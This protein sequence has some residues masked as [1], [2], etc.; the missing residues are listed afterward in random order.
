MG[1]GTHICTLLFIRDRSIA[2]TFSRKF[3]T[4]D[5]SGAHTFIC[6]TILLGTEVCVICQCSYSNS[7]PCST[8][9]MVCWRL[10][11]RSSHT[12]CPIPP[13]SPCSV[14]FRDSPSVTNITIRHL[15][16]SSSSHDV[17]T[18]T[19]ARWHPGPAETVH[20]VRCSSLIHGVG[21]EP[22]NNQTLGCFHVVK[23][24][25]RLSTQLY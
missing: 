5:V 25:M 3:V 24:S 20:C 1:W 22:P 7:G 4:A 15:G 9:A 6:A 17:H 14:Y 2:D 19:S 18:Y 13:L 23:P 11:R 16:L 10:G 21:S 8:V 12:L